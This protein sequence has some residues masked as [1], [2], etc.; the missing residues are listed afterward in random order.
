MMTKA[1][2]IRSRPLDEPVR[3][4]IADGKRL[5]L[6]ISAG[7]VHVTRAE[8]KRKLAGLS[9][10]GTSEPA[11]APKGAIRQVDR[12]H[13]WITRYMDEHDE[14]PSSFEA[15]AKALGMKQSLFVKYVGLLR[16]SGAVEHESR[17]P[18]G[19]RLIR[20]YEEGAHQEKVVYNGKGRIGARGTR[21]E[22]AAADESAESVPLLESPSEVPK[23]PPYFDTLRRDLTR[24]IGARVIAGEA[25]IE[26]KVAAVKEVLD[27]LATGDARKE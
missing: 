9:R 16:R 20:R 2:F 25:A 10:R 1:E 26:V 13:Q 3:D 8:Y 15:A 14:P 27:L 24:I 17:Q 11:P 21:K 4:V 7:Q 5:K 22:R 23:V 12:V 18:N 19:L 6:D